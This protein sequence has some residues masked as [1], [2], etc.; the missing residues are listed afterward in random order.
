MLDI[1][2]ETSL[3]R[4]V[5]PIKQNTL[6]LYFAWC[7]KHSKNLLL[8][9]IYKILLG[10]F[11]G[12]IYENNYF[13]SSNNTCNAIYFTYDFRDIQINRRTDGKTDFQK[14][15]NGLGGS[16]KPVYL[17]N[18]FLSKWITFLTLTALNVLFKTLFLTF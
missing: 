11:V 15:F 12:S 14:H 6:F 4:W 5:K 9:F 10:K 17:G 2:E 18:Q 3:M 16:F 13:S 1:V 7:P 8:I